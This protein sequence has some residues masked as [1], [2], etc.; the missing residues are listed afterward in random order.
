MAILV[1]IMC[2]VW[3]SPRS[4]PVCRHYGRRLAAPSEEL[5]SLFRAIQESGA[6]VV[7]GVAR[8]KKHHYLRNLVSLLVAAFYHMVFHSRVQP[9]A[10]RILRRELVEAV[11]SYSLNFTFIDGLLAWNT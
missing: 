11:L 5:P 1:S 7:Y 2:D 3:L 4:G 10:F 6:D 8:Q 9:S